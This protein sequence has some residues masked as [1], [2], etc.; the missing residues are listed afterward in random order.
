MSMIEILA[1][2]IIVLAG[3]FLLALGIA[4]LVVPEQANRFLLGFARSQRVHFVEMFLRLL[5]GA[6]LI[7]SAPRILFS[8]AFSLFGWV[9][10]VSSA[11]LLVV[12]W[13]WHQRFAQHAVPR[14]TRYI[15]LIG[16]ASLALGGV[17]LVAV[18]RGGAI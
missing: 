14:A 1:L 10:L 5:V 13:R 9:L 3:L 8:D 12:P 17:I 2:C 6:A 11:C 16:L 15:A 18:A 4:S 7:H